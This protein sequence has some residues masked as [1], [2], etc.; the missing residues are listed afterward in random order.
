MKSYCKGLL[1]DRNIISDAY[2]LWR[3]N[4]S[5][6]KNSWRVYKEYGSEYALID[7][8]YN[9]IRDRELRFRPLKKST[10]IDP[11]NGKEREIAVASIKQQVCDY[12][13]VSCM[14]DFLKARMG[15]YQTANEKGKGLEM[16]RNT[17]RKW[18]KE[19][20][21]FIKADI[22]KCYP[23]IKTTLVLDI[24]YKYI[25]S[26]DVLYVCQVILNTY[27]GGLEIGSYFSLK[28][29]QLVLSFPYHFIEDLHKDRRGERKM[30]V[31][32]Q[33][34]HMDDMIIISRDKRDLKMAMRKLEKYVR[35]ELGLEFKPWK[36]SRISHDEPLDIGGWRAF[37]G[38]VTIRRNLFLRAMRAFRRFNR[39][40]SVK[41]AHRVISYWGWLKHGDCYEV[42]E[43]M[44]MEDTFNN[45]RN[46]I[47][48]H[49]R[50]MNKKKA[51]ANDKNAVSNA[52]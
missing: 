37:D 23:S 20:A 43:N 25:K 3:E 39:H 4:E 46:M 51:A 17:I 16:C 18:S 28:M 40:P 27:D 44:H 2:K 30:L 29:A 5:G 11:S 15:F 26:N 13:C 41:R 14:Q 31:T 7:E 19:D 35:E 1:I 8:I 48:A 6:K 47:S 38:H 34:W 21:Y 36:V 33:I 52:A 22:R 32:H 45:A 49:Q 10:I 12:V 24:L 50:M 42:I 9:E